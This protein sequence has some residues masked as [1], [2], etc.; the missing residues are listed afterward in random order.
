MNTILRIGSYELQASDFKLPVL[1]YKLFEARL[2]NPIMA[3]GLFSIFYFSIS[4]SHAQSGILEGYIN[5]GLKNN[6]QLQREQL[7]VDKSFSSLSQSRSLFFPQVSANSSYT[8]AGGGRKIDIQ[9]GDLMNPVYEALGLPDRAENISQQFLPNNFHDTKVRFIQPL[10][11]SDIYYGYK[12]Q[13]ELISVQQAQKNT[14]E[15]ELRYS[16][17]SSYLQY[18]QTEEAIQVLESTK[19]FLGELVQLNE[20]LVA[21]NKVTRDVLSSS[22]YEYTKVDQQIAEATKNNQTAKAY[23]NFL[24]NRDWSAEIVKDTLLISGIGKDETLEVLTKQAW[25]K[26]QEIKQLEGAARANNQLVSMAGGNKYLPKLSAVADLGY[27]GFQYKF[28]SEQQYA[29]LQ[30][31]LT[32][33]LFKGGEKKAKARQSQL[34]QQLLENR[35]SQTKKQIELE[36]IQASQEL[37]AAEKSFVAS[38]SGVR[39]AER[40]FQIISAK[41]R[42]G[43]AMLIELLDSQNKLTLSRLALSV[44]RYE[45]LRKE[46]ALQKA[47]AGI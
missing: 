5:E 8:L 36:V 23:F 11:N 3:V 35:L 21:N 16:I 27:Q 19:K 12:A 32:W 13:K 38:Q 41:Y 10:F 33:D 4:F 30:F 37:N 39:S 28:N 42:E 44:N 25:E 26:R 20:K 24:L 34:D 17:T 2:T 22:E 31:N 29:L 40:T 1:S 7:N 45:V 47:V 15:N 14:Y 46:A 18:L 6:L 9:V 43:Q